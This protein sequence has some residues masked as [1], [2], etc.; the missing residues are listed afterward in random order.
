MAIN[1]K[2]FFLQ[3]KVESIKADL[4]KS[5][6]K[7]W[8]YLPNNYDGVVGVDRVLVIKYGEAKAPLCL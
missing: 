6:K 5:V 1:F 2:I 4:S 3:K 7:I 8:A